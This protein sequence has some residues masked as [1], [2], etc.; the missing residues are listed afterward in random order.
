MEVAMDKTGIVGRRWVCFQKLINVQK[1]IVLEICARVNMEESAVLHRLA[2][3]VK[4]VES[5]QGFAIFQ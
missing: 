4:P 2:I 5:R 1:V 3:Q